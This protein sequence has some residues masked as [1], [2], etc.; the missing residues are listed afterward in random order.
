MNKA[1]WIRTDYGKGYNAGWV[2]RT[3]EYRGCIY[4]TEENLKRGN[5]MGEELWRQ[6]KKEQKRIDEKLDNQQP[7]PQWLMPEEEAKQKAEWDA[8]WR[9]LDME[10]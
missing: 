5:A 10:A 8:I 6:H 2:Y 7:E 3:Y 1:K 4:M 9:M